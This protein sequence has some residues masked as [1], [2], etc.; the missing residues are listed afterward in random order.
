MSS[1][2]TR[3]A[4]VGAFALC[5]ALC[6]ADA[7][8]AQ[9]ISAP[10]A[11]PQEPEHPAAATVAPF[12][13]DIA[14]YLSVRSIES[15]DLVEHLSY[16]EYSG[17][18]FLSKTI[19][20]WLLHAEINANTAPEWD[21]EGIHL[22]PPTSN[23]SVKLETASVNYNWR[24]WMQLQGG[25]LFVP[26]YW[27]THRY[28]STT[29]TV[30][31]PLIDQAVFPTAFKGVMIHGDKYREQ[32]GISYQFYGGTSQQA[33][34]EDAVVGSNLALS[35]SVG[36]KVV[37]HIPNQHLFDTLDVGFQVHHARNSDTSRTQIY[38]GH[39]SVEKGRFHL[40]GEFGDASIGASPSQSRYTR[41]GYYLQPS[42]RIA[43]PLFV[44][45]RYERLNRD[46]RDADVNRMARQSVGMTYRPISALSLKLD[47]ER[48][49]PQR[50]R[51]PPYYGIG[52]GL[53]Y[54][55]RVP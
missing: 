50:G 12:P 32:G 37:W 20:R 36:A 44:V 30:D 47:V 6:M 17:S 19:G 33:D 27:R 10:E 16:R 46:S 7:A 15:D 49:E 53:V 38:G 8:R 51:V 18:V 1:R 26:T 9:A 31:E 52:A 4:Q 22:L 3:G 48:F 25:F 28:H 41:Q 35:K 40:L 34:F 11:A 42:Y 45:A 55:F 14:G 21:S 23:L 13:L 5:Q 24:D 43:P 54:F 39:A 29:L 2:W